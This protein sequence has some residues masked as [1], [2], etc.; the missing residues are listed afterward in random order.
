M[1]ANSIFFCYDFLQMYEKKQVPTNLLFVFGL[2][3]S[4]KNRL[5]PVF[6]HFPKTL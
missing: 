5:V 3:F 2:F 6:W 1:L 4:K